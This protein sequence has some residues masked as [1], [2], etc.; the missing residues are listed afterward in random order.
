MTEPQAYSV[1]CLQGAGH[2][3][4]LEDEWHDLWRQC[5]EATEVQTWQWQHLYWK[6]IAPNSTPIFVTTRDPQGVLV[7]LGTF[8]VRRHR[9]TLLKQLEFLGENDA[10]YH[11]ILHRPDVPVSVGERMVQSLV[12]HRPNLADVVEFHNIPADSWTT[13][14]LRRCFG[15][16]PMSPLVKTGWSD[17]YRISL[18]A[19]MDEYWQMLGKKT[20]ERLKNGLRRLNKDFDVGFR[21]PVQGQELDQ[22]LIDIE[23]VNRKRWGD[24]S[25]Y[26][27]SNE[28]E[29]LNRMIAELFR[30]G[31]CR[32]FLMDLNGICAAYNVGFLL[33][34][35]MK[36]AYIACDFE[37]SSDYSVG[38]LANVLTI[39]KCIGGGLKTYDLTRGAESYKTRLGATLVQSLN[40]TIFKSKSAR[41]LGA[42]NKRLFA[43]IFRQQ[44]LRQLTSNTRNSSW[45]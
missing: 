5:S 27:N 6:Q 10:D 39:E 12:N 31:I 11:L 34:D 26:C 45:R 36:L 3:A 30:S 15:E 7:A 16:V 35:T 9:Q 37:V 4:L 18:P 14:V 28:R 41:Y 33:R 20:R 29:F 43:P 22:A 24:A 23:M 38:L 44:W 42:C 2:F 25:P 17:T 8:R 40:M 13:A 32:L 21:V 1:D 19:S